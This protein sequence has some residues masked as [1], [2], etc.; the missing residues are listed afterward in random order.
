[1][2]P[3]RNKTINCYAALPAGGRRA[4]PKEFP[5]MAALGY[6]TGSDPIVWNCGGSLISD[7]F[8][9]TAAHCINSGEFG[10]V[11]NVR[12]GALTIDA[13]DTLGCPEEFKVIERI[14]HPE[15][16]KLQRY[17]D[18]ALLKLDRIVSFNP[19]VR[20]ACLTNSEDLQ[21][22]VKLTGMGWGQTG[23]AAPRTD[24]LVRVE[25]EKYDHK[26]C[27]TFFE[28]DSKL[29]NGIVDDTQLCAGSKDSI[30]DTCPVNIA[31][32]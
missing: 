9:L 31:N 1:M 3:S 8:V 32:L 29:P 4:K 25:I 26:I 2:T 22:G 6:Q 20:P 18:V 13:P 24:W 30:D 17:N 21:P 12:L 11:Q 10:S 23:F 7:R 14:I 27:N 15:Y 19:H 5:H 16:N 28:N